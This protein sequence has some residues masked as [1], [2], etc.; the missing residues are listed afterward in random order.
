MDCTEPSGVETSAAFLTWENI[1]RQQIKLS[2]AVGRAIEGVIEAK[3]SDTICIALQGNAMVVVF[4][5]GC[6]DSEPTLTDE[7][8]FYHS[9]FTYDEL[10]KIFDAEAIEVFRKKDELDRKQS[11]QAQLDFERARYEQLK[12]KFG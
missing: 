8:E 5:E 2:E 3:W 6:A 12:A 1:M 11:E 10:S 9:M 4:A 7:D